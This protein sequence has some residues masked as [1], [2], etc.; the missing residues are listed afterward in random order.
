M[1]KLRATFNFKAC[2]MTLQV[3]WH[4]CLPAQDA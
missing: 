3:Y 2:T 1:Q 4:M